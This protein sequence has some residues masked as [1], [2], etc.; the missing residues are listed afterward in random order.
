MN[1]APRNLQFRSHIVGFATRF[2]S[3]TPLRLAYLRTEK[4][5]KQLFQK[6]AHLVFEGMNQAIGATP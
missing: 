4:K 1:P 6:H 3:L 2:W 5:L